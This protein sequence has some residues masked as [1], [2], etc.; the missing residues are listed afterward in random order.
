MSNNNNGYNFKEELKKDWY[1]LLLIASMFI[2]SI[3]VYSDLPAKMPLHWNLEGQVDSYTNRFWGAFMMPLINIGVLLMMLVTPLIDPK[4][5]NYKKFGTSYRVI[6]T[7]LILFFAVLHFVIIAFALG[8]NFDIGRIMV[9]VFGVLFLILGNYLP[10]VRHNYFLG[11]RSPWTL[12]SEK[13]WRKTQRLGGKLFLLSGI[14]MLLS[15]FSNDQVRFAVLMVC[16]L[17]TTLVTTIYSY[18][19]YKEEERD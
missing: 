12:A 5:E 10:R 15:I 14:I 11:I 9:L 1:L 3:V 6:R 8:Y 19:V 7:I 17:G 4:K 2:V 13:V 18:F 16:I